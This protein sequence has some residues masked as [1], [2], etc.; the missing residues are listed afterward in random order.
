MLKLTGFTASR[1]Y[2]PGL[3]SVRPAPDSVPF[4]SDGAAS[5]ELSREIVAES[6]GDGLVSVIV[7]P[8]NGATV[9]LSMTVWPEAVPLITGTGAP[10]IAV[11]DVRSLPMKVAGSWMPT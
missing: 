3:V 8:E 11:T 2:T 6:R 10:G 7:T 4:T 5:A 9:A 1:V